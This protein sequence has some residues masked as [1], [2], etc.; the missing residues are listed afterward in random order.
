MEPSWDTVREVYVVLRAVAQG[1]LK[2]YDLVYSEYQTLALCARAHGPLTLKLV[3]QSLGVTPAATTDIGRRLEKRH[4]IQLIPNPS[5]RRSTLV[6]LAP[7]GR[8]LFLKARSAKRQALQDLGLLISSEGRK[9]LLRGL[10]ELRQA[11][12][13]LQLA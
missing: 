9:G 6:I 5:D 10:T 2:Q 7:S 3:T 4:L 11:I 12:G 1:A 8:A 13:S